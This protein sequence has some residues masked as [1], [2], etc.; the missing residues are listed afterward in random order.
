M[1]HSPLFEPYRLGDLLLP[2]RMIMAPLTRNRANAPG[3]VPTELMATYYAQR[4]S[5]G[6]II[7]EATHISAQAVGYI[8]APGLFTLPQVTGWKQVTQA[9]HEAGGRIFAQLFHT[10]R[11]SLSYFQPGGQAHVAPSAVQA[12]GYQATVYAYD[13]S[14]TQLPYGEPRALA[15][16]EIPGIISDFAQAARHAGMADFDGVEVHGANGYLLEQFL[17]P[18]VNQRT[19]EWGGSIENRSRLTLEVT[20]A[21]A[22]VWGA[23]RVGVRFSPF[24]QL[25]DQPPYAETEATYLYLAAELRK[26][27]VAYIHLFNQATFGTGGFSDDFLA[28]MARTFGGTIILNGGL[29][30]ETGTDAL[31]TGQAHLMA[32]GRAFL[33]NPDLVER[34][35]QGAP[36]NDVNG[37]RLYGGGEDGYTDYPTLTSQA[38]VSSTY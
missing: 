31:A 14:L 34:F 24:G 16:E 8:H 20:R 32:Y 9:V 35:R 25:H 6:L 19:D 13:G 7:S 15:T 26:L 38:L 17:N 30:F 12:Q 27:G 2:N 18:V 36:L 37:A 28:T 4:A 29:T 22:D 23:N 10:G 11:M 33:A 3:D 21:I 1:N 5:A